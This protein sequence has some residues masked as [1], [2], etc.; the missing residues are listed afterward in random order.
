V[1]QI[2]LAD[3]LLT[4]L[5]RAVHWIRGRYDESLAEFEGADRARAALYRLYTSC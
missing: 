4:H 2:G 5:A 1:R 3:S